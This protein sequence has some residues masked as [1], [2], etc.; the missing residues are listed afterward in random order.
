LPARR[1][2]QDDVLA[3]GE[4]VQLGEMQDLLAAQAGLKGEV[5][6][7]DR[8]A[9]GEASGLD[10]CLAAVAVATVDLGL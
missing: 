8:L 6:L 5:E 2:Q 9:R 4:E 3:A 10:P 1:A 7:L